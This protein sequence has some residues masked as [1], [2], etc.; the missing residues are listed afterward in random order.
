MA[1][2]YE[3]LPLVPGFRDGGTE[4]ELKDRLADLHK[5]IDDVTPLCHWGDAGNVDWPVQIA[6][7]RYREL[8]DKAAAIERALGF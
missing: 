4:A 7:G 8:M 2:N 1:Q 3:G 6:R 5:R